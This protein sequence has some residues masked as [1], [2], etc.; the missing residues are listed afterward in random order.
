VY[1]DVLSFVVHVMCSVPHGSVHDPLLFILHM[2][3][4]ADRAAKHS[5][6]LHAYADDTQLYLHLRRDERRHPPINSSAAC[7]LDIGQ[8]MSANRLKLNADKTELLFASSGHCCAALKGSY[9][10]LKLGADTAVA[11]SHVR[12]GHFAGSERRSS[13]LSRL[14]WLLLPTSSTPAYPAVAGL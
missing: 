2:A 10:V 7:V 9:P 4:L 1:G 6:S 3:D 14:R 11:S 12:R 8:R 5:V 13:R